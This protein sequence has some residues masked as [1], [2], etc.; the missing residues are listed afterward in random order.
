M[1]MGT[2]KLEFPGDSDDAKDFDTFAASIGYYSRATEL[3][4]TVFDITQK[5]ARTFFANLADLQNVTSFTMHLSRCHAATQNIICKGISTLPNI[6]KVTVK[7]TIGDKSLTKQQIQDEAARIIQAEQQGAGAG[8]GAEQPVPDDL[9]SRLGALSLM[10]P[11][12]ALAATQQA[13]NT[14]NETAASWVPGYQALSHAA[15]SA[16]STV[17]NAAASMNP[18]ASCMSPR[19]KK[20]LSKTE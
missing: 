19:P 20:D 16:A 4:I 7:L 10:S 18:L 13:L 5:S 14:A 3:K 9:E 8:A 1:M 6:E 17:T 15:S 11:S 2:T 12:A